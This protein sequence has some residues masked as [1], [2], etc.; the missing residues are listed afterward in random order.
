MDTCK[1]QKVVKSTVAVAASVGTPEEKQPHKVEKV[2]DHE[3]MNSRGKAGQLPADGRRGAS[4]MERPSVPHMI[5][6]VRCMITTGNYMLILLELG[7]T[8]L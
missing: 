2:G 5:Q 3:I 6:Q 8:R 1:Q 4:N 7:C